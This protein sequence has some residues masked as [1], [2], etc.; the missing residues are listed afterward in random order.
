MRLVGGKR[1]SN[2]RSTLQ[3]SSSEQEKPQFDWKH[4]KVKKKTHVKRN[5]N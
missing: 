2:K 4:R 5:E 3:S 1:V